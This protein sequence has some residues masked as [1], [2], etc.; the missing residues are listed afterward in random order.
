MGFIRSNWKFDAL[1]PLHFSLAAGTLD[2]A[3][4]DWKKS[5]GK[6][7]EGGSEEHRRKQKIFEEN[8]KWIMEYN[9]KDGLQ[10]ELGLGPF[11]DLTSEEFLRSKPTVK[12]GRKRSD[13]KKLRRRG[14]SS[15][16][17]DWRNHDA[18]TPVGNEA[19]CG[20]ACW[21]FAAVSAVEGFHAIQT[22][23]LVSLSAQ[24]L[25][26]CDPYSRMMVV[27]EHGV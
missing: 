2:Q 3:F 13:R 5:Y 12:S 1:L 20:G 17:V 6:K 21:A 26:D 9:A 8:L 10:H 18:V 15:K 24:Q 23:N 19:A 11:A 16:E 7:Y 22:G 27:R 25:V 4:E 14:T